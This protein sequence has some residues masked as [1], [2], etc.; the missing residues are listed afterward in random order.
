MVNRKQK[1]HGRAN[2]ITLPLK[3]IRKLGKIHKVTLFRH[4][5]VGS[6]SL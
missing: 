1:Y 3:I 6:I 2:R 4:W 5:A